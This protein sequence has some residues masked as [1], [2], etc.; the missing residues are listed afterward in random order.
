MTILTLEE[1]LDNIKLFNKMEKKGKLKPMFKRER[2]IGFYIE[3]K[4]Y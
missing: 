3:I 2:P 1:S 4:Q